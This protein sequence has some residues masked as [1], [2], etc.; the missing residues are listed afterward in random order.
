M[1]RAAAH[2]SSTHPSTLLYIKR[3]ASDVYT[4][5]CLLVCSV[6]VALVCNSCQVLEVDCEQWPRTIAL[7]TAAAPAELLQTTISYRMRGS[8][9]LLHIEA[10]GP[11]LQASIML[12]ERCRARDCL[13]ELGHIWMGYLYS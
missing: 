9:S 4:L 6:E 7:Y 5:L 1:W 3:A 8:Y 10:A 13:R 12:H 11:C 2:D